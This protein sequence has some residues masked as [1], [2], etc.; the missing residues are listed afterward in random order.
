MDVAV[1]YVVGCHL[2]SLVLELDEVSCCCQDPS[3]F[4]FEGMSVTGFSPSPPPPACV[5]F[6]PAIHNILATISDSIVDGV[7]D[8][9]PFPITTVL[10]VACALISITVTVCDIGA[11]ISISCTDS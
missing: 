8:D 2:C 10:T 1:D 9:N 11:T 5:I 4:L 3:I 6:G 7:F